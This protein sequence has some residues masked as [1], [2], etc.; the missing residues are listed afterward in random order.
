[1][2]EYPKPDRTQ[3]ERNF[4][5]SPGPGRALGHWWAEGVLSGGAPTE[6]SAIPVARPAPPIFPQD[7]EGGRELALQFG[8]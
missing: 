8:L 6:S 7:L 4:Q 2:P 1:V 3:V 5:A